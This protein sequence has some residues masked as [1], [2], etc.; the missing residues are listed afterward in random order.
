[1]GQERR[2]R[3]YDS[4]PVGTRERQHILMMGHG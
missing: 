2:D 1:V 3:G 4:R